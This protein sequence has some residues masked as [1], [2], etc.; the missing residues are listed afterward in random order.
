MILIGELIIRCLSCGAEYKINTDS[1]DEDAYSIGEFSMGVR[2]E[3]RFTG[4][5]NVTTVANT[6]HFIYLALSILLVQRNIRV[7]KLMAAKSSKSHTWKWNMMIFLSHYFRY[8][9]RY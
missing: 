4:E 9:I 6:C 1:L 8:M 5:K 3:H 2:I 7:L